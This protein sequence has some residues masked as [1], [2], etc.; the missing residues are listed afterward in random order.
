MMQERIKGEIDVEGLLVW[1]FQREKA[2]IYDDNGLDATALYPED[3]IVR[4]E[5]VNVMGGF[6]QGTTPGARVIAHDT[7]ADAEI[8]AEAVARLRPRAVAHLVASHAKAGNRPD[9]KPHA[10]HR[11][12]PVLWIHEEAGEPYGAS[13]TVPPWEYVDHRGQPRKW[14]PRT[15]WD[16]EARKK[17]R[18]PMPRWCRAHELDAP[19]VVA[20]YRA[21]YAEWAHALSDLRRALMGR[22]DGWTLARDLPDPMPWRR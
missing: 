17:V 19:S 4:A 9:W 22:L 14:E 16:A 13:E 21:R 15:E 12:E 11:W 1:A 18:V 7:A 5:R 3:S 8:V 10:C 20:A 2:S 6:I